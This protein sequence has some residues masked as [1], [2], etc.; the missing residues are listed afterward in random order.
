MQ[1]GHTLLSTLIQSNDFPE[2]EVNEETVIYCKDISESRSKRSI[3]INYSFV[4]LNSVN[5]S[6]CLFGITERKISVLVQI[7]SKSKVTISCV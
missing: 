5:F 4:P 2:E 1:S 7:K 6:K 3:L